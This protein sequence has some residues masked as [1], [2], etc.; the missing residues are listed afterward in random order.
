MYRIVVLLRKTYTPQA[1]INIIK[2]SHYD[3][4]QSGND[5]IYATDNWH[6]SKAPQTVDVAVRR[7]NLQRPHS[8][9]RGQHIYC[10]CSK[11]H[12]YIIIITSRNEY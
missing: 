5:R 6:R 10:T 12:R 2:L 9:S 7:A 1:E 4:L 3:A 11:S 8:I